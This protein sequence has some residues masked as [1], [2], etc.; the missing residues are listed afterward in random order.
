MS[1]R[2]QEETIQKLENGNDL[3][4]D[5]ALKSLLE[6]GHAQITMYAYALQKCGLGL[7]SM[8]SSMKNA[9]IRDKVYPE[10]KAFWREHLRLM[11]GLE[12]F[13]EGVQRQQKNFRIS[14]ENAI[15]S[16]SDPRLCDDFTHV[17]NA[18]DLLSTMEPKI[19]KNLEKEKL[20]NY[21]KLLIE[22]QKE[23]KA[24]SR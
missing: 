18:Y 6:D 23:L 11:K 10:E 22:A 19:I 2:E 7:R 3:Q 13:L 4:K 20:L 16:T 24:V 14:I 9:D 12:D 1:A 8:Q 17:L 21:T 5:E 15:K